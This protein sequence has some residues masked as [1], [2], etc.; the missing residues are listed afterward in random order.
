MSQRMLFR[1]RG[2]GSAILAIGFIVAI[3]AS[4]ISTLNHVN[5]QSEALA[6]LVQIGE[7]YIIIGRGSMSITDSRIDAELASCLREAAEVEQ[8]FL[9][10]VL[11]VNLKA[12]SADQ[13]AKLT[14]VEKV[15]GFLRFRGA[16]ING[17]FAENWTEANIGEILARTAGIA[18]NQTIT[19]SSGEGTFQSRVV[20]IFRTRSGLDAEIVVPMDALN[21]LFKDDRKISV[22]E[23]TL[24]EGFER[25]EGLDHIAESLPESV[26][27]LKV[28]RPDVFMQRVNLQTLTFLNVWSLV[29]Y[30]VVAAASYIITM[31][32]TAESA[33][34][35]AML[36]ALGAGKR[37]VLTLIMGYTAAIAFLGS[38]LGIALGV[39]GT[40]IAS[41][42]LRW[43]Q[44]TVEIAPFLKAEQASKTIL[45]TLV[46]S[47][48]GCAYPAYRSIGMG[49]L[50]QPL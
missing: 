4:M 7:T 42:I 32:L 43:L 14:A 38:I 35:L 1:R 29:V 44:P 37:Q 20:G 18:L 11:A 10:K 13:T 31:R 34:E 6:G 23:F 33:Y 2:V 24:K 16:D 25:G 30:A 9:Q 12:D 49:Y 17:G 36:R 26:E 40:Q 45:L 46:S 22:I 19:I 50:E 3:E 21:G 47:I 39:A 5:A 28:Q 41:T 48:L 27:I 8:I 15:E